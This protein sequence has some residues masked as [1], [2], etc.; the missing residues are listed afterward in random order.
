MLLDG[1][2]RSL[3]LASLHAVGILLFCRGFLLTRSVLDNIAQ[4]PQEDRLTPTFD[5]VVILVIDALRYDF[6]SEQVNATA[7]YHNRLKSVQQLV[8]ADPGRS[9]LTRFIADPPTTTLQRLKGLTTGSLPTFVDAGSNF[10]GTAIAEDNWLLQSR[11]AGK[12]I[13]F[14]G[15]DTWQALFPD[16]FEPEFNAPYESF[17]VWDLDTLDRGVEAHL[18]DWLDVGKRNSWD[19]LIAHALGVDHAGHRYGTNHVEL[20][21]KLDEM[22]QWIRRLVGQISDMREDVLLIVMGDHGMNA[23][24]DHG[25]DSDLEV[26]AALWMYSSKGKIFG[27]TSKDSVR[28]IDLVP[29]LS[30]LL[31]L[32]TPFNSLGSP[33]EQ[34]FSVHYL[35]QLRKTSR[36][37]QR[38]AALYGEQSDEIGREVRALPRPV[39]TSK[40]HEK[41]QRDVLNIFARRW[42]QYD[43]TPMMQGLYVLLMSALLDLQQIRRQS[44]KIVELLIL[45]VNI[46]TCVSLTVIEAP[47][48]RD[49]APSICLSCVTAQL[50]QCVVRSS[51]RLPDIQ[52]LPTLLFL[53]HCLMFTSNSFIIHEDRIVL[54][55]LQLGLSLRAIDSLNHS[56]AVHAI[57]LLIVGLIGRITASFRLCREEQIN[58]CVSNWSMSGSVLQ[59]TIVI[60]ILLTIVTVCLPKASNIVFTFLGN[61]PSTSTVA[62]KIIMHVQL[63]GITVLWTLDSLDYLPIARIIC[64]WSV[65]I[66]GLGWALAWT[67]FASFTASEL[68]SDGKGATLGSE[69]VARSLYVQLVLG[70]AGLVLL[71]AKPLGVVSLALML[72]QL[73]LLIVAKDSCETSTMTVILSLLCHLHFFSTGHQMTLSSIQWDTAFLLSRE[74][75]ALSP[76][77]V[78]LNAFGAFILCTMLFPA[79]VRD[80][81]RGHVAAGPSVRSHC[82]VSSLAAILTFC[83]AS[84]CTHFRRHLMVWKIFA[85]RFMCAAFATLVTDA[86]S[87]LVGLPLQLSIGLRFGRPKRVLSQHED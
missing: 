65:V 62:L 26:D 9:F 37:I 15:D 46:G 45:L 86:V 43:L 6:V 64:A 2:L 56:K 25:G 50:S 76:M 75:T 53:G 35:E 23:Q 28:Q 42:A 44:R 83:S 22:D 69:H 7:V 16:T 80:K 31:G 48:I 57:C 67:W 40:G 70:M 77:L 79:I 51:L 20:Q 34:A 82:S 29:T 47:I 60:A 87:I 10:A 24:G 38:Y 74:I 3:W 81:D 5:K 84:M 66:V 78:C 21:R 39:D 11:L 17:N 41:Y 4:L 85:P 18:F 33:I 36:Q 55:L 54:G 49:Y 73:L 59:Q 52:A 30:G 32:P 19:I 63:L 71:A 27:G 12:R 58:R 8:T 14:T 61:R 1:T 68:T 13:A 72:T